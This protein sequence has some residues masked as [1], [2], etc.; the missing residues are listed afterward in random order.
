MPWKIDVDEVN[1]NM[2]RSLN[3]P[4][5][6]IYA[7]HT[8]GREATKADYNTA[9]GLE[10]YLLL[11]RGARIMLRANLWTEVGLV[12]ELI[13]II[14]EILFEEGQRP[15]S[16]SIAVLIEFNDYNG[17]AITTMEGKRVVPILPIRQTWESK[18]V[19]CSRLQIPISLAWAVTVHKSQGL[20]LP[21]AIINLG[22]REYAVGL[23]FVAVSQIRALKDLLFQPFSFKRL[24]RI[25]KSKRLQDRK[26]EEKWL[27]S[28]IKQ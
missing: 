9:K 1:F 19:V 2:L 25:K 4:I 17:P 15:P 5:A 20:T 13:G 24:Q 7:V 21:K 23:S 28:L 10:A 26:D 14:E 18:N 6:K 8:G 12:N 11:A 3:C 27:I 16:L 22:E